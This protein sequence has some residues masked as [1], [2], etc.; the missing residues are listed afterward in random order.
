MSQKETKTKKNR[1]HLKRKN[2]YLAQIYL[3][4][5]I[6]ESFDNSQVLFVYK[7]ERIFKFLILFFIFVNFD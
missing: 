1:K 4:E 5:N 6:T 7:R 3:F 2:V